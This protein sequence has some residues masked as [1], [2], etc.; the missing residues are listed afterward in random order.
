VCG[1]QDGRVLVWNATDGQP[2][3][4][5]TLHSGPVMAVAFSPEGD[6][7]ATASLDGASRVIDRA[8]LTSV[9]GHN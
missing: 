2:V 9:A 1:T 5:L 6:K 3:C 4:D 7:L 8:E